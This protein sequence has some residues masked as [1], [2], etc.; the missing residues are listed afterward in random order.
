MICGSSTQT[1]MTSP[2]LNLVEELNHRVVNEYTEA[3]SHLSMASRRTEDLSAR[4]ILDGVAERLHAYAE[5]HRALLPPMVEGHVNLA[6]YLAEVCK[7]F[8]KARLAEQRVRLILK[9]DDIYLPA[10]RGWRVGLIA[11]ELIRNSVRHGL[12]G[13][14]GLV[15]VRVYERSQKVICLVCDTGRTS[16]ASRPG[17]GRRLIQSLAGD[18]G[19]DINWAL[20]PQGNMV[21][22]QFPNPS[23]AVPSRSVP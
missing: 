2:P 17:R 5:M 7:T 6:D 23:P 10:D 12:P 15:L 18:L 21:C 19:G 1:D 13:M 9:I 22:L 14:S 16:N 8:A 20:S 11:V 3:I 4:E